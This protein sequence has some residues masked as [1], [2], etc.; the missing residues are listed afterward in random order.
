MKITIEVEI[1][2]WCSYVSDP[3]LRDHFLG[4][5]DDIKQYAEEQVYV[6]YYRKVQIDYDEQETLDEFT[7]R[8]TVKEEE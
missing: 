2:G 5:A 3:D 1:D 8:A 6:D 4:I 7:I